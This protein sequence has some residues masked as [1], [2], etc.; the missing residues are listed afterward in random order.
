MTTTRLNLT[1]AQAA[2]VRLLEGQ[3]PGQ[4]LLHEIYHSV[5]GESTYAGLPCVFVRLTACHLRC[6][7]C[8]TPHAFKEGRLLPRQDVL[9]QVLAYDCPLVELTGGE[10]LLQDEAL[11]LMSALADAGKTVLVE[12]S[13]AVTIAGV[14]PRVRI[15]MDLKCPDSGEEAANVWSNLAHIKPSDEIKFVIASRRDFD[16]AVAVIRQHGLEARCPLLISGV[17]DAVA[18]PDVVAWLLA[19]GINARFQLQMHKFIWDP[20]ARGV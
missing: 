7:W 5:Q 17:F 12:T 14:D 11:P 9:A 8:D 18:P 15:I 16:W 3:P 1:P 20:K 4:L 6:H 13:G 19:S 2:R 10:P